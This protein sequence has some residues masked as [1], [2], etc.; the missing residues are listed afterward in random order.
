MGRVQ[1]GIAKFFGGVVAAGLAISG[2]VAAGVPVA[3]PAERGPTGRLIVAPLNGEVDV[4]VAAFLG[5]VVRNAAPGDLL[6]LDIDTFGGRI[7][8]AVQV[9]DAL[10][11][12]RA[13]TVAFV[14]PRAISAGALIAL[15]TDVI[16]M[17]RG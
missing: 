1:P 13:K 12:C 4:G 8:A 5:R 15:A 14:H 9:R 10:L 7:D 11:G 16:A 6:V 2:V 3:P 17:S